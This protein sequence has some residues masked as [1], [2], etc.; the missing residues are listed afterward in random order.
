MWDVERVIL[1][2]R[3]QAESCWVHY[4]KS[5]RMKLR[6]GMLSPIIVVVVGGAEEGTKVLIK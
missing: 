5:Q 6:A 1:L 4:R 2:F 3:S